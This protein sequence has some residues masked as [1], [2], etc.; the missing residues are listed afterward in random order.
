MAPVG[1]LCPVPATRAQPPELHLSGRRRRSAIRTH[2][3][4]RSRGAS[5][6]GRYCRLLPSRAG[7]LQRRRGRVHHCPGRAA[8]RH[9]AHH[10]DPS[11]A[12]M[13]TSRH[14][15][16]MILSIAVACGG[17]PPPYQERTLPLRS[18]GE[19]AR[20]GED[21][22]LPDVGTRGTSEFGRCTLLRLPGKGALFRLSARLAAEHE[23]YRMP[24]Q[25]GS[26]R[27]E[28]EDGRTVST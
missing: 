4:L 14:L 28:V 22:L 24:F 19:G 12:G 5:G 16:A 1:A 15:S 25:D 3:S 20:G 7:Q 13:I 2:V 6:E 26:D 23:D 8:L 27:V 10:A 18:D 21:V 9:D 11:R 17:S